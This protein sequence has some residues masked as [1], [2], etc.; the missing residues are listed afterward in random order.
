M[1]KNP[2]L[3]RITDLEVAKSPLD[4]K[5]VGI[6]R[7][8]QTT[9]Q[10]NGPA[11][12]IL[13]EIHSTLYAYERFL[14]VI[15]AA[16][17]QARYMV[18]GVDQDPLARFEKLIDRLNKASADFAAQ[19]AAP[20]AWNRI[21][22]FIVEFSDGQM[23][24]TGTGRLMNL[25]MQKQADGGYRGFD[26]IGSLEQ[27][28]MP[29][30]AKPFAS[31]ICGEMKAGDVFMLGTSNF[32]R[33]RADLG[34][35]EH[36]AN[37]PAVTAAL[38]IKQG[39]EDRRIPDD[40][41]AAIVAC[42]EDKRVETP[43]AKPAPE[44]STSSVQKLRETE[45][46]AAQHLGPAVAPINAVRDPKKL[47]TSLKGLAAMAHGRVVAAFRKRPSAPE[48]PKDP[49][50]LASL[51][52]MNAGYGSRFTKKHKTIALGVGAFLLLVLAGGAWW[53]HSMKVAAEIADWQARHDQIVDL[54]NRADSDLIYGNEGKAASEV[55]EA[56]DILAGLAMDT[57]ER[58][59]KVTELD[60]SLKDARDKLKKIVK[61]DNAAELGVLAPDAA[62]GSL[63][64]LV[65]NGDTLYAADNAQHAVLKIN[66]L[67]RE[68]KRIPLP[69]SA[70]R[71]VSA[72]ESK[73]GALFASDEGKLYGVG[74][75]GDLVKAVPWSQAK[76]STTK[77][78]VMYSGRLYSLDPSAGQIWRSVA[79]D[80]GY[81]NET[82]YVKAANTTLNDA[83]SLA[84][85]SNVYVLKSD[86]TVVQFAQGGQTGFALLPA[87]PP[88]SAPADIWAELDSTF[89]AVA[90]QGGKRVLLY[91]KSG[92][93]HAQIQSSQLQAPREVA[94]DEANK[95]LAVIDGN[96]I[97]LY[98]LP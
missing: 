20:L 40:F 53:R 84:I 94:V 98:P 41:V 35:K 64:A 27:P 48:R 58:K 80:G 87:D 71:I 49:V 36:L 44:T 10:K 93:L 25:F 42:I 6:F 55:K 86:G 81:G 75:S 70:S 24:L 17:E 95:R 45:V 15:N 76:S 30:P 5:I 13:A 47:A 83:V 97:L 50:A 79:A 32:E 85:D 63:A 74:M 38:N 52:G 89:I 82:A 54:K 39:I 26:I 66:L 59:T 92:A 8:D 21:N 19:E 91:D 60:R 28:P 88:L 96:R 12:L 11:L 43:V 46:Q 78:I 7:Y 31:V 57:A 14:D 62:P 90:D 9:R 18:S 4:E 16:T 51:R 37:S 1:S 61:L 29:D 2:L 68:T 73:N 33:F 67:N 72:A 77:D 22:L 3:F 56:S 65:M 69:S 34:I 23:C